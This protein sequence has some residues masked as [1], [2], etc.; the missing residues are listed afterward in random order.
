MKKYIYTIGL[1]LSVLLVSCK[2]E[3]TTSEINL[4]P[5]AV[6]VKKVQLGTQ[7]GNIQVSGKTQAVKSADLGTRMMGFVDKVLVKVGER[8]TK[9]QLLMIIN[10]DDLKAKEAQVV[11]KIKAAE[12]AYKN[13]TNDLK[14]FQNLFK[15]KS[16]TQKELE[17][18]EAQFH[19]AKA[20]YEAALEM[21]KEIKAQ[22]SYTHIL[23]PFNGVIT[24]S[25]VKE[26]TLAHPGQPIISIEDQ[27]TFEVLATVP[28]NEITSID[29]TK[30]VKLYVKSINR[31]YRG[32]LTELSASAKNSN[33]QYL[34]KVQVLDPDKNIRSGMFVNAS[35]FSSE[36]RSADKIEVPVSAIVQKGQLKG[37][38]T[39][40]QSGTAIL[41]WLRLGEENNGQ[42]EVLSGL[43]EG[44]QFIISSEGKLFNGVGITIK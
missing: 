8:V 18:I 31:N 32:K 6:T 27:S 41:R 3:A 17:N 7:A 12:I 28:E 24:S 26:G 33:G 15:K 11:A 20:N 38:Y 30:E 42:V 10:S 35:I 5:V 9:G 4:D 25:R 43:S 29:K 1:L 14:R 39:I 40:S 44:E 21:K 16:A 19:L 23:A 37:I 22:L 36:K 13:A 2:E 34:V